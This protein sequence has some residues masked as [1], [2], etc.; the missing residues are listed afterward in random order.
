MLQKWL[1]DLKLVQLRNSQ[2][3]NRMAEIKTGFF[4]FY[5]F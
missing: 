4:S 2:Y 5:L 1:D 3:S